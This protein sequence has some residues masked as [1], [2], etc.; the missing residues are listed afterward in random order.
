MIK[1]KKLFS[2]AKIPTRKGDINKSAYI[3]LAVP[4]VEIVGQDNTSYNHITSSKTQKQVAYAKGDVVILHT[5]LAME[6]P[7]GT[8]GAL[9]PRSSTFRKT[10]LL[11]TNSVGI[12]DNAYCGEEDEWMAMMYATRDGYIE[13][14]ADYLQ[15]RV[16]ENM[17][18]LD[19]IEVK[20]LTNE[21]RGG[22]GS[23]DNGE[24]NV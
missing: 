6:L 15:F 10:G 4:V 16:I 22:Y 5:G 3:D 14:G 7:E 12:I 21:S 17:S 13:L 20:Q 8:Y 23:T 1:V 11:M 2:D 19:I 9:L 24:V 18:S